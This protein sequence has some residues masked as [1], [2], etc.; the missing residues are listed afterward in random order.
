MHP[1]KAD[2]V[3][4]EIRTVDY[5]DRK[6]LKKCQYLEAFLM[7]MLR[8]HPVI[9]TGGLRDSPPEGA[10]IGD[11]YIPGNVTI[12]VPRYSIARCELGP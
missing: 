5:T 4:Q 1:E 12:Q 6:A 2:K 7:E 10:T 11:K 3:Y 9:L 8:L